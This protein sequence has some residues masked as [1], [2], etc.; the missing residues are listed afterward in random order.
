MASF[1]KGRL[2]VNMLATH[3]LAIAMLTA[4][5]V[6]FAQA[7]EPDIVVASASQDAGGITE[8]VMDQALL[9]ALEK[10]AVDGI[11]RKVSAALVAQGVKAQFPALKASSTYTTIGG[12]KLAIVK[13][14]NEYA[15]QVVIHGIV[16]PEFR[17]V[18]C[19]RT[20]DFPIDIP[21]FYGTCGDAVRATFA[22]RG[23]PEPLKVK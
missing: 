10:H 4:L 16:G 3:T 5:F 13:L 9:L 21:V 17:R 6:Q 2:A 14:L 18:I 20:R 23:I 19:I 7:K 15:N 8:A 12:K 22:L 11:T 1:F